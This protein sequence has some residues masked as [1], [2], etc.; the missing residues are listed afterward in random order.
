MLVIIIVQGS[1][2]NLLDGCYAELSNSS[3]LLT[4]C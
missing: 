3:G 2:E 1:L 4:V